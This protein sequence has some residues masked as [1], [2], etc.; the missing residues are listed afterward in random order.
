ML[1]R[2]LFNLAYTYQEEE[3][4]DEAAKHYQRLVREFPNSEYVEKAKDQLI[5]MGV[6]VPEPNPNALQRLPPEH[7]GFMK[8]MT[9]EIFGIY[10]VTVNKNGILISKDN[11]EGGDL[12]DIAIA[13]G[14]QLPDS[15]TPIAPRIRAR[16]QP[17]RQPATAPEKQND[18]SRP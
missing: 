3:E 13:R 4:P 18:G 8:N 7:P 14:G 16:N 9:N 11:N 1:D 15:T 2:V 6:A 12:I 5:V 10:P 17:A